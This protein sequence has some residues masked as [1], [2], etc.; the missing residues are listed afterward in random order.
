MTMV[1]AT[2]PAADVLP[3]VPVVQYE[4]V[5]ENQTMRVHEFSSFGSRLETVVFGC[6]EKKSMTRRFYGAVLINQ[7]DCAHTQ[8]RVPID[9]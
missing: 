4:M 6:T 5:A 9:V 8:Q 7:C 3:K 2:A 1:S